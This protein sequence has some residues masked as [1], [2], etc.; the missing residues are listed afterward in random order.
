MACHAGIAQPTSLELMQAQVLDSLPRGRWFAFVVDQACLRIV[1]THLR[2]PDLLDYNVSVVEP[3][4]KARKEGADGVY[5]VSP[6]RDSVQRICDDFAG[7]KPK[8]AN[9]YVFFS[10]KSS[11]SVKNLIKSCPALVSRLKAL[12]EVR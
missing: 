9:A 7:A 3:L 11:D 1:S 12:K 10:S 2:L 6:T 5:F 8:Y 4:E